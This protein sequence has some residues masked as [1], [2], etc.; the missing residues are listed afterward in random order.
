MLGMH[1]VGW[2][3]RYPVGDKNAK[4]GNVRSETESPVNNGYGEMVN[5]KSNGEVASYLFQRQG[6][7]TSFTKSVTM[8]EDTFA[9]KHWP[10]NEN[11]EQ[12]G[13]FTRKINSVN[14]NTVHVCIKCGVM[15]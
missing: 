2:E 12:V 3:E 1:E 7:A 8:D 9:Q 6:V 4:L 5:V 15:Y 13:Y 14:S 11:K 10:V